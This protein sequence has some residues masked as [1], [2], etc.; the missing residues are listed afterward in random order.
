[1]R[2]E[3]QSDRNIFPDITRFVLNIVNNKAERT[4]Y[5]CVETDGSSGD[6]DASLNN[7]ISLATKRQLKVN[8]C[9]NA[10]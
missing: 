9:H 8:L 10:M 2:S 3:T 4:L 7:L 1:M 6:L 5:S